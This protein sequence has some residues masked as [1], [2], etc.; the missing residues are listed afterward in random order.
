MRRALAYTECLTKHLAGRLCL[1]HV[2]EKAAS[3]TPAHEAEFGAVM[4][5]MRDPS[6][7]TECITRSGRA[8]EVIAAVSREK[9][10]DF[11]VM[12]VHGTDELS[13]TQRYGTAYD[14][15][16]SV[17]CP[18]FTLFAD[19]ADATARNETATLMTRTA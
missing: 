13:K 5:D 11:V 10:A 7:V 18:V 19:A 12:G 3:E 1:L 16:R 4:A 8:A 15:I 6:L 2:D 9:W 17:R 14:V